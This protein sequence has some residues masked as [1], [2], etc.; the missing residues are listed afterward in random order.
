VEAPPASRD[1]TLRNLDRLAAGIS[2]VN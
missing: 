2:K 1:D